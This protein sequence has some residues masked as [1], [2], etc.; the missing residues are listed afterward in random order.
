MAYRRAPQAAFRR[1]ST[2]VLDRDPAETRIPV[3][4]SPGLAASRCS[5]ETG[6]ETPR[7][8]PA[9]LDD[10]TETETRDNT[11]TARNI[12]GLQCEIPMRENTSTP[13]PA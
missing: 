11:V 3:A 7:P 2:A 13:R 1:T 12:I 6:D 8:R 4:S 10:E 5:Y 9:H